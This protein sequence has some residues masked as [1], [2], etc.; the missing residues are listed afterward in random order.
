M[1]I[2]EV[3]KRKYEILGITCPSNQSTQKW[4]FIRR[5]YGFLQTGCLFSSQIVYICNVP[6]SFME[7]LECISIACTTILIFV[8]YSAIAFR[9]TAL[10]EIFDNI[11]K[12]MDTRKT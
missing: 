4:S 6:S 9:E 1:K 3:V 12:L 10:F 8:G 7:Y 5:F 11:E 2:F